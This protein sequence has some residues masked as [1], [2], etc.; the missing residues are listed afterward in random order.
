MYDIALFLPMTGLGGSSGVG[1]SSSNSRGTYDFGG[2]GLFGSAAI[3]HVV[4][5]L[6]TERVVIQCLESVDL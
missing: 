1:P 3:V 2:G 5:P 4:V 6:M